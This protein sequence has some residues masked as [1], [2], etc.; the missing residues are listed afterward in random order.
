[1]NIESFRTDPVYGNSNTDTE[2]LFGD[3]AFKEKAPKPD[4]KSDADYRMFMRIKASRDFERDRQSLNRYAMAVD[5]D[6]YDGIQYDEETMQILMDRHQ[7]PLVFNL[8]K[9]TINWLTGTERRTR[10][11]YKVLP[12]EEDDI[13]QAEVKTKVMKFLSDV[14]S[15]PFKRSSA[16]E[17]A[18]I[19]GVG[20]LEHSID[21]DSDGEIISE[22]VESWRNVLH[23]SL[24]VQPDL[25]DGRYLHRWRVVDLDM[26]VA[27][28]P[29]HREM[30]S[31]CAV[32][33]D[34]PHD[35]DDELYFLGQRLNSADQSLK[36]P[37]RYAAI[38]QSSSSSEGYNNRSRV[39]LAMTEYRKPEMVDVVTDGRFQ[40]AFYDPKDPQMVYEKAIGKL[41]TDKRVRTRMYVMIWCDKG[42]VFHAPSPF[43]H[44]KF[45][46]TPVWGYRRRRDNLPYGAVRDIRDPQEDFNK[47][48]SKALW[49]LSSNKVIAD[50][51]AFTFGEDPPD[52]ELIREEAARPDAFILKKKGSEVNFSSNSEIGQAQMQLAEM[53]R[54]LVQSIAG[55]TDANLG[56]ETNATSGKAITALQNQ[57]SV[58]TTIL[59]DNFRY[60]L[61]L[62]GQKM[63]SATEQFFTQSKV[64]RLT[65]NKKLEW[66]KVNQF[67]E[68]TGQPINDITAT[69]MDFVIDEVDYNAS[70]RDAMMAQLTEMLGRMPPE[71]ALQMLDLVV[72]MSNIANKEELVKRIRKING[73][74]DPDA[75]DDP[76]ANAQ[77]EAA[78]QEQAAMAQR[79][80]EIEL[81]G[82]EAEIAKIEAE[83]AR[84]KAESALRKVDAMTKKMEAMFTAMQA[85]QVAASVANVTPIADSMLKT[86]GFVDDEGA[87]ADIPA[88]EVVPPEMAVQNNQP[89]SPEELQP[90]QRLEGIGQG[91]ETIEND[92]VLQEP[93][94]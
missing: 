93:Q 5:E 37:N 70:V 76:E 64:I 7:A 23:D 39:K 88:P 62:H 83:T 44:N 54:G 58:V 13:E 17:S 30:L 69:C 41:Y 36:I 49:A 6:F 40:G 33:A 25:S 89:V 59:F 29:A 28:F 66:I 77:R 60:A 80:Q 87:E 34:S 52:L 2:Y 73:Q 71:V 51:D 86:A 45:S 74:E 43:R 32:G 20:W 82:A 14:N 79:Q 56:R 65:G 55:V 48:A 24:G 21:P 94:Q 35:E 31:H 72:D 12:R 22:G 10:I 84:I 38:T 9:P 11:D 15:A 26:A 78:E 53:D 4:G 57:G 8:I 92:S 47:R 75:A 61:H 1:M 42:P 50:H 27:M 68:E 18:M 19:A 90:P 3:P 46:L 85:A 91:I 16:F 63:L 81:R 67:D